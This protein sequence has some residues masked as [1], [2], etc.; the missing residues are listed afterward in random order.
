MNVLY[1]Y[2]SADRVLTCLPEIGD[3]TLRATQPAALNDPFECAVYKG[4]ADRNEQEGIRRFSDVLTGINVSNPVTEGD[5]RSAMV[6]FGSLY[7]RELLAK[8]L[9]TRF[10]IVSFSTDYRH[11]L[12]WSHYTVD[13]SGFVIG[14]DK[15]EI[16]KL[17][18][19]EE[20]LRP[21]LYRE[22]LERLYGYVTAAQP[23]SNTYALLS[24]KS[25]HWSYE[26]EWRLIVELHASIGTGY[27][28]RHG[29]PINL[30]RVPNPAV[31]SVYYTE[32]TPTE[33]VDLVRDRLDN[34]N[35]RYG[36]TEPTKLILS[37]ERYGYEDDPNAAGV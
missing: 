5:V 15:Q 32:R 34:M 35:N 6:E 11:P 21:V 4:F 19:N 22:D 31:L 13:G 24:L 16:Q 14:Y 30:I 18:D 12:M 37:T 17:C 23:P 26:K 3:G 9:S 20:C 2:V 8:Q 25:D 1:K 33:T 10:G 7:L 36:A 27:R 28:D 29:Q